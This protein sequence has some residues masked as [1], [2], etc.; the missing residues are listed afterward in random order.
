MQ[1]TTGTWFRWLVVAGLIFLLF[2]QKRAYLDWLDT[3][4]DIRD[5]ANAW[6]IRDQHDHIY[7]L[8]RRVEALEKKTLLLEW[9]RQQSKER[10]FPSP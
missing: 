1:F 9:E 2:A 3:R 6:V 5:R 7:T 10:L 4:T 8:Q